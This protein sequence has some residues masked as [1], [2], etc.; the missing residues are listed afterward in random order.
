MPEPAA[1]PA[2]V[3]ARPSLLLDGSEEPLLAEGL[4]ALSV[5]ESQEG[6][7]RCE[8][9]LGNWG[10]ANGGVGF[11]YF[12]RRTLEFGR[13]LAVE[14][15]A[16]DAAGSIF[17]GRITAIEGRF[18]QDRPPE[19]LVLAEDRFQDL[20]M[21]RR[22][23][24]FEEVSDADVIERVAREHGLSVQVDVDG[25]THPVLA[26]VN[27]S[28]LAFLRE[29][30]RAADA[31]LWIEG[32]TLKAEARARRQTGELTLT[33]GQGLRELSAL[34]DLAHQRTSLAVGGWDVGAKEAIEEEAE[35]AA[36]RPEL[37]GGEAGGKVLADRFGRRAERLV[38]L[39]PLSG[40]EAK[41]L[42]EAHYRELAR[43]FVSGRGVADGDAR[44]RVGAR[45]RLQRLGEL[46]DGRYYVTEVHHTFDPRQGFR[47]HFRVERPGLGGA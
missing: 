44:L 41:A 26:Q 46:F 33:Y 11:L 5:E 43:R 19:V 16:G 34:A 31:E 22:T 13:R 7:Y 14:M 1:A 24:T 17:E 38:H 32:D 9:T 20:R 4:L 23:R 42:A 45:V 12:D 27:L 21:V 47:T 15:G 36:I 40:R 29:R 2:F 8:A 3:S 25:P 18:P 39:V 35:E 37:D 30:A 10:A 6:I 28:D